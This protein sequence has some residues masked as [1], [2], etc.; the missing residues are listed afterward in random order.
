MD[1]RVLLAVEAVGGADHGLGLLRRVRAVEVD[2][3]VPVRLAREEREVAPH[4]RDVE[5]RVGRGDGRLHRDSGRLP[6]SQPRTRSV[7]CALSGCERDAVDDLAREGERQ[8]APRLLLGEGAGAEVEEGVGVEPSRRRAVRALDVVVVDLELRLGVDAGRVGEEE[9]AVL[10]VGVGEGAR[11]A[12]DHLAVEGA[13]RAPVEDP[14]VVLLAPAV[15]PGV[16]DERVVVDLLLAARQEEP[17]ERRAGAV[18]VEPDG[19]LVPHEAAAEREDVAEELRAGAEVRLGRPDVDTPRATPP[20]ASCGRGGRARR[21]R[22][23][24]PGSRTPRRSRSTPRRPSPARSRRGRRRRGGARRPDRRSRRRRGRRGAARRGRRRRGR[25]RRRRRGGTP[26]SSRRRGARGVR[27]GGRGASRGGRGARRRGARG[28]RSGRRPGGRRSAR[29]RR[30]D[31]RSRRRAG[32]ALPAGDAERPEGRR[33]RRGRLRGRGRQAGA[34][35]RRP[36]K[37]G[38][39]RASVATLV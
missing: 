30:R 13:A 4:G 15:R 17:V 37:S 32:G 18:A 24:S 39:R 21:G 22:S 26:R 25:G 33:A 38:R 6:A 28:R 23:R 11:G 3:G 20:G 31:G 9:V 29:A 34:A 35:P 14:L 36:T 19:Q 7:R 8:D 2:E 1:V 12:D 5:G 27:G 10:L 16:V